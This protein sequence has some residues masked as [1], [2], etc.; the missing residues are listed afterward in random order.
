[1]RAFG[2]N[3]FIDGRLKFP[4]TCLI[5]HLEDIMTDEFT[6]VGKGVHVHFQITVTFADRLTRQ[7][8]GTTTEG[9]EKRCEGHGRRPQHS[10]LIREI[11]LLMNGITVRSMIEEFIDAIATH[12]GITETRQS[13]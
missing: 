11:V 5:E 13:R 10:L 2:M 7:F 3:Q 12:L 9:H 8:R 1:M 6:E 4:F